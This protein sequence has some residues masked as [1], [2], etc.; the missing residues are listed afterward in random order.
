MRPLDI[1]SITLVLCA[2]A[3]VMALPMTDGQAT[4]SGDAGLERGATLHYPGQQREATALW[5]L[6]SE[7][8]QSR[9]TLFDPDRA[10][11]EARSMQAVPGLLLEPETPAPSMGMR[12]PAGRQI[13]SF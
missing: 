10:G 8:G 9:P 1:L 3:L 7:P 4:L 13:Y 6:E 2:M 5:Q 11:G 12:Y